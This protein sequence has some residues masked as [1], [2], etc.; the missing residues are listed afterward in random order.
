MVASEATPFCKTGGLADVI[1]SLPA[2]LKR[3]GEDV[4]VVLP[5]YRINS[6]PGPVRE[7]FRNLTIPLG[8]GY[9][10]DIYETVE[11][12]VPFYFIHCPPLY[13]RDGIYNTNGVDYPDNHIR[14]AVLS[15]AALSVARYLF[16]PDILHCHDWQAALVPVYVNQ[17][18]PSD[19]TFLGVKTLFTIH[20]LGYQGTFPPT[21]MPSIGLHPGL[22]NPDQM[23]FY[24]LLNFMK[25]G[26]FFA[27]AVSTVSPRYAHEIQ[28]K[29]YGFGLENFLRMRSNKITGIL[30]GVDY[31]EWNPETDPN[32]VRNYSVD[33]L[34]GKGDCKRFLQA[35][36]G[37]PELPDRPLIGIISRF[38]SQKGFD[39]VE[40][41]S[42]HLAAQD[43]S[44]VILGSGDSHFE[45]FFPAL[46]QMHPDKVGVRIGY[47]EGFSHR[48]EAGADMFLMPSR[49]EPCGLN[50]IFSLRYGTVPI[51]RA[52]GGLDDTIDEGTGF[53]FWAY[54]GG[55]LLG[56]VQEALTVY[57][58]RAA[59]LA[60]MKR[61]MRKDFSW[62][63]SAAE[64]VNLYRRLRAG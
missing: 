47:D 44:L 23:E 18:F 3:K 55:E 12:D 6:Y 22:F 52:T 16:R 4:A 38:A 33:D 26:I 54:S 59:W 11:R 46:S 49:Y 61:G 40:E 60:M 58:D 21:V 50:Q 64:Y 7:V 34:S 1:G 13:D 51:V 24:G 35:E 43:L 28:T 42:F 10:V 36:A 2:A 62:S 32:L 31:S 48:I 5:A 8:P 17:F 39:L 53:K 45:W 29:E 27:D 25:G 20:N 37:L 9:M 57:R 41:I 15:M 30:N 19:P 56:A 14:F 63:A